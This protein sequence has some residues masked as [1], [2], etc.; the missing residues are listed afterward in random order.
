MNLKSVFRSLLTIL[1]AFDPFDS[2]KGQAADCKVLALLNLR[3][4]DSSGKPVRT[5]VDRTD[6]DRSDMGLGTRP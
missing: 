3:I 5:R 1:C 6:N 2:E 4:V